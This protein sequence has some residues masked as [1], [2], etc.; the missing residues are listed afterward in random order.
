MTEQRWVVLSEYHPG[1]SVAMHAAMLDGPQLDM[2][3]L[4]SELLEAGIHCVFE[5]RRPGENFARHMGI[6]PSPI[7]LMVREIDLPRAE[8]LKHDLFP[9][10]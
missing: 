1:M 7:R 10:G 5:P 6:V 4:E 8:R 3:H 2:V 9:E